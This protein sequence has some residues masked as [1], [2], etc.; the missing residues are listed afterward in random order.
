MGVTCALPLDGALEVPVVGTHTLPT[1]KRPNTH[2]TFLTISH[3][4]MD[5]LA[6]F[7]SATPLAR[8]QQ[9]RPTR[10]RGVQAGVGRGGGG[11]RGDHHS[12]WTEGGRSSI[13]V[14]TVLLGRNVLLSQR[15]Q[16]VLGINDLVVVI[17]R[18]YVLQ[19]C[20]PC[21]Y[22]HFYEC[23]INETICHRRRI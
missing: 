11:S 23:K 3:L 6:A 21:V 7:P 20:I 8:A 5:V 19:L 10:S 15:S 2:N 16:P 9:H 17:L 18:I 13:S 1:L 22:V 4:T 14:E 12:R